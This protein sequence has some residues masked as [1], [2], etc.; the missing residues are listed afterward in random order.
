MRAL[1]AVVM[2]AA[3]YGPPRVV[4]RERVIV[5]HVNVPTACLTFAPPQKP[6]ITCGDLNIDD[7]NAILTA[8][9][10]DYLER[11]AW[12][13]DVYAWPVCRDYQ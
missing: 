4:E 8:R 13:V 12:W 3:C 9:K 1:I 10:L 5:H 7:C 11:L 6:D 2:V